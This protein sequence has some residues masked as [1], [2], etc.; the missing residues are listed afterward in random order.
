MINLKIFTT[1]VRTNLHCLHEAASKAY[2][3]GEKNSTFK[4][5]NW[6][7]TSFV[8]FTPCHKQDPSL[9]PKSLYPA[10]SKY[11]SSML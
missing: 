9:V 4:R 6:I 1:G 5:I 2:A 11:K 7:E 10:A 3:S 8:V